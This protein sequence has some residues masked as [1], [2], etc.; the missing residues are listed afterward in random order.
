[1]SQEIGDCNDCG[2]CDDSYSKVNADTLSLIDKTRA[3]KDKIRR[4]PWYCIGTLMKLRKELKEL[5]RET[6]KIGERLNRLEKERENPIQIVKR[7]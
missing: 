3:V 6:D 1:M 5:G 2:D 7:Q 4:T